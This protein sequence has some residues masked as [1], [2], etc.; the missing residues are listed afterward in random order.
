MEG[1]EQ[2]IMRAR[3]VDWALFLLIAFEFATGLG[4]FLIGRPEGRP[5]FI[6]HS[7]VGLSIVLLVVWKWQRVY[8]R[9]TEPQRWQWATLVSIGVSLAVF[10]TI[11]T[12]VYWA[13]AQ[14]PVDYP[15]GMILHTT[16]AIVL[17]LLYLWHL[18]LRYKPLRRRDVTD[19]RTAL[20]F[21]SLFAVGGTL[22]LA[23]EAGNRALNTPGASR[24]F[25]GSRHAG[26]GE[27]NGSFP[28][29][30]WM[31]DNPAPVARES[32]RLRV[33]GEVMTPYML[34]WLGFAALPIEEI[35]ATLDCTGGW[36]TTQRWRGVRLQHLLER[37][38]V[39]PDATAVSF[40][41]VTG[42]RWSLT[43]AEAHG[44]LLATHVGD[45]PLAHG[46]GAPV[47]LVAPGR[48]GFQWVK[49]VDGITVLTSHDY[50]QWE[51]IF[52]SGLR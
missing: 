43:L 19:R 16:A 51:R 45:E 3:A 34:D 18:L 29:T 31:F 42:Y 49:W 13:I 11:G 28:V 20:R 38:Q 9:V 44:A 23:Q 27:G 40:E 39:G 52:T 26:P 21:L 12:G 48:R 41:S 14:R 25:T 6:I 17:V 32:W 37:A 4:S 1:T 2:D 8:R 50:A 47:R 35:E 15:N 22:W 30:M 36:Y 7:I 10:A 24:R 46:H 5:I 33:G